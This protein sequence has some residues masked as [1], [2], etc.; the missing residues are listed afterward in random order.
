ELSWSIDEMR[1]DFQIGAEM[2]YRIR[3]GKIVG[4]IRFPIY[5][6]NTLDFWRSCDRVTGQKEWEFWGF[7]DC[8]KGGPYQEAFTGHR[9]SPARFRKVRFGRI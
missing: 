2:G 9:V 6:G 7:S 5:H 3:K 4:L 8:G 1:L